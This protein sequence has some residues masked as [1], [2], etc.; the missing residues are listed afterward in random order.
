MLYKKKV[1]NLYNYSLY[2]P[3]NSKLYFK[4]KSK[5]KHIKEKG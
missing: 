2:F 5:L 1:L 4:Y 3:P